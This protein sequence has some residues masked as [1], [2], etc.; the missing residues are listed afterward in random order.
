MMLMH[1]FCVSNK[2][3]MCPLVSCSSDD[4]TSGTAIGR[5]V[6]ARVSTCYQSNHS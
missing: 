2:K 5:A 4:I 3:K 6:A 1:E